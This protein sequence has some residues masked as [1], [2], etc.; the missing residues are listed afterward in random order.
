[1]GDVALR[2]ALEAESARLGFTTLRIAD[3]EVP[4]PGTAALDRWLEAGRHG[5]MDYL[6]RGRDDRADPRRRLPGARSAVV[7]AVDHAHR[8]PPDP[9]G[10]TGRVARYAWGR[11]Y[12]NLIG[13]RLRKLRRWLREQGVETWGGVDTAAIL[14]RSWARRAGLGYLGKNTLC[15]VPGRGSW[16][17]LAVVFTDVLLPPDPP[18][19]REYCGRCTRCLQACPTRAFPEAGT[20][21]ATRCIAYWTIE[22]SG[23]PPRELRPGFRRWVFGCD[24]CQEVCPHNHAPPDPIHDD[25]RPVNAWLDLDELLATPDEDLLERFRGTPLRRPRGPG[26]KR[27]ALLVLGN[28]GDPEGADAATGAL[29]HPSPVVRGAAVWA[30]HRLAPGR[31]PDRDP[32]PLVQAEIDAPPGPA[33]AG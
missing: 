29:A 10:R 21:D 6:V 13:K 8:V 14:E 12:H 2:C 3:V 11:D 26:L 23:L 20:L 27:N 24:V 31:V 22:A 19:P 33:D 30:L 4:A 16:F 15:I 5:D 25:L 7:L 1:M 9:G 18:L 32:D 17:F 28:L